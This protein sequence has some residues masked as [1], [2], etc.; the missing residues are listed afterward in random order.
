MNPPRL[1]R[2]MCGKAWLYRIET[3]LGFE[4]YASELYDIE[5]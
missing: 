2:L 1:C 4:G 3:F 5:A